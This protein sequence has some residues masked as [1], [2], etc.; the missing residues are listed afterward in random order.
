M[1]EGNINNNIERQMKKS[2]RNA[3]HHQYWYRKLFL[4]YIYI[5]IYILIVKVKKKIN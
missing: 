5:Y 4:L 2:K 3:K 1:R